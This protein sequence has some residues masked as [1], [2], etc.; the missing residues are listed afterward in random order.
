MTFEDFQDPFYVDGLEP[1]LLVPHYLIHCFLYY[2]VCRAVVDDHTF[3]TLARR[4]HEEWDD[5]DHHHKELIE[6]D[7]LTSGGSYIRHP[8]RVRQAALHILH[9]CPEPSPFEDFDPLGVL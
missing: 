4:L 8:L 9:G 2:E 7:A 1:D 5:V 3:D 6:W